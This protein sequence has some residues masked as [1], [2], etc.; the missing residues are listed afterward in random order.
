[1]AVKLLAQ[2]TDGKG[3]L[4]DF[5]MVSGANTV[6][7]SVACDTSVYVGA[8]VIVSGGVIYNALAD[9]IANSNII[10]VVELKPTATTCDVRVSGVTVGDIFTGLDETKEYFLSDTIPG[11]IATTLPTLSGHVIIRVGQ[12]FDAQNLL[13]SKGTRTVRL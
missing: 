3:L 6:L 1:M 5:D 9:S 7:R 2:D 10:G 4:I 13:V 11:G 8:V 12:P